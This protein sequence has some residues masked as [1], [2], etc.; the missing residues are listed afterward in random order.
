MKFIRDQKRIKFQAENGG[1][2]EIAYTN[3]GEPYREG[4]QICVE[5]GDLFS[6]LFIEK[7]EVKEIR[8]LLNRLYPKEGS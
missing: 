6:S 2:L 5:D 7:H 1:H 8:D 3:M 4:I